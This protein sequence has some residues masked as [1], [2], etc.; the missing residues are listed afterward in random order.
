MA[1]R[2]LAAHVS[3]SKQYRRHVTITVVS[4]EGIAIDRLRTVYLLSQP[5][6]ATDVAVALVLRRHFEVEGR[7]TDQR[8]APLSTR[9]LG[10]SDFQEARCRHAAVHGVEE[11]EFEVLSLPRMVH[12]CVH[13]R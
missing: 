6:K 12:V 4:P 1:G 5:L 7:A 10:A 13:V 8:K 2:E 11:I 3:V 9:A